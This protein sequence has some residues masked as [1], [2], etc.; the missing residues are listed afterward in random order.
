MN[1]QKTEEGVGHQEKMRVRSDG[2]YYCKG[3]GGGASPGVH[4][5]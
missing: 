4:P 2:T 1:Q 5:L 3:G